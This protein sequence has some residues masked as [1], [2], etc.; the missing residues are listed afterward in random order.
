MVSAVVDTNIIVA[1]ILTKRQTSASQMVL[2]RLFERTFV[3]FLSAETL[4]EIQQVLALPRIQARHQL[5]NTE[6]GRLCRRIKA[7]SRMLTGSLRVSP[8]LTRDMT[9]TKWVALALEG[10][11][12][13]LVTRDFRH[14][15]RLRTVGKT[16][17]VTP[18]AFIQEL[19]RAV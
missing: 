14:L 7:H 17:I 13:Y 6:I 1:G 18:R 5:T 11:A 19:D 10:K 12:D 4:L 15:H 2:E 3:L 8:A 9:D 16:R